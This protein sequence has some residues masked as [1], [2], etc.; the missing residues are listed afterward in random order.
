MTEWISVK[1]RLPDKWVWVLVC[2]ENG[3]QPEAMDT[4]F[5]GSRGDWIDAAFEPT[6]WMPLPPPP[7]KEDR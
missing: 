6:H 1:E 7:K 5:I 4:A 3:L 2:N